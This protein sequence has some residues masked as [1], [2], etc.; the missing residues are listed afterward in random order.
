[1][2]KMWWGQRYPPAI[3]SSNLTENRLETVE[4]NISSLGKTLNMFIEAE[5]T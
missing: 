3:S 2:V 1:M 4:K 5:R